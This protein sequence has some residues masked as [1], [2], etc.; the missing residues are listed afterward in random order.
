MAGNPSSGASLVE[1]LDLE[2]LDRD[3]YRAVNERGSAE[4]PQLYGGQ[5]AAQALRAAAATVP[6]GRMPHSLHGYFLRRG[7]ADWPVILRV[8]R[9][10]DG[11]SFSARHVEAVQYG[12][13]IFDCMASFNSDEPGGEY[14]VSFP[15]DAPRPDH[16]VAHDN[17]WAEG[18]IFEVR[19]VVRPG[20]ERSQMARIWTRIKERLPDDPVV[21]ACGI[22]Y[23]SDL[24]NGFGQANHADLWGRGGP[25]LDHTVWFHRPTRAD[26]WIL[27]DYLPL[28]AIGGRGVYSGSMHDEDGV[29]TALVAQEALMRRSGRSN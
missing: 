19:E 23:L 15:A 9:A 27:A 1:L 17:P 5:V 26:R 22:T 16:G 20:E 18:R 28:K 7:R 10:R 8:G 2:M 25:S 14:A 11:R 24:G 6:E 13:V 4:R 3:L 12:E 21:H 29:L